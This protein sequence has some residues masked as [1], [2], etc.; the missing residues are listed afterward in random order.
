MHDPEEI[1]PVTEESIKRAQLAQ[2]QERRQAEHD[3][4]FTITE[5]GHCM[6]DQLARHYRPG[7]F[8]ARAC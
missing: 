7:G 2:A 3:G 5:E 1:P 4:R 8:C 6:R